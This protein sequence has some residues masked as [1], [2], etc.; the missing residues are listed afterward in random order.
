[1]LH[2]RFRLTCSVL[3][4]ACVPLDITNGVDNAPRS[5]FVWVMDLLIP[6]HDTLP[7]ALLQPLSCVVDTSNG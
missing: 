7:C 3:V 1:M 4:H 5:A 6:F 2:L